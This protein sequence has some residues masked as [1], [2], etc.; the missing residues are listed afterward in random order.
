[1]GVRAKIVE[2]DF[3]L[4][5]PMGFYRDFPQAIGFDVITSDDKHSVHLVLIDSDKQVVCFCPHGTWL[6]VEKY[7]EVMEE[8]N[9]KTD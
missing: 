1:M 8:E 2:H 9:A 4:N 5:Q 6:Y 3:N 7:D